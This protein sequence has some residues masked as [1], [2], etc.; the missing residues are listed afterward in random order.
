MIVSLLQFILNFLVANIL[1]IVLALF[2]LFVLLAISDT[3]LLEPKKADN[4]TEKGDNSQ[5]SIAQAYTR[6]NIVPNREK[7]KQYNCN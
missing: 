3:F 2:G 1:P 5:H 4:K 6:E 7:K